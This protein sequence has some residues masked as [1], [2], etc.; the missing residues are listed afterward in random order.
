M[1]FREDQDPG[2]VSL[3]PA[4]VSITV[5]LFQSVGRIIADADVKSPTRRAPENVDEVGL[6]RNS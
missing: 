4:S 1:W 5:V 2:P 3:R 6:V